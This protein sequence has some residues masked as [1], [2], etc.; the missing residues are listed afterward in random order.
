MVYK[1]ALTLHTEELNLHPNTT[2]YYYIARQ[3][4]VVGKSL[5]V[6]PQSLTYE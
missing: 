3:L 4:T 6:I 5:L 1:K 2:I